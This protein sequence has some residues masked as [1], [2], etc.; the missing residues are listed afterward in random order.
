MNQATHEELKKLCEICLNILKENIPVSENNFRKLK[1]SS[2]KGGFLAP[3]IIGYTSPVKTLAEMKSCKKMVPGP[4]RSMQFV[5]EISGA[6]Y[7]TCFNKSVELEDH[8]HMS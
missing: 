7:P 6:R 2:K 1:R 3:D 8:V 5:T 4:Q